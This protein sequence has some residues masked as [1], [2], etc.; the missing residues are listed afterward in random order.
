MVYVFEWIEK[1]QNLIKNAEI[2]T[3]TVSSSVSLPKCFHYA[4]YFRA[5]KVRP[6]SPMLANYYTSF[7]YIICQLC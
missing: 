4:K 2:Y 5:A 7:T 6:S 1:G 3:Y